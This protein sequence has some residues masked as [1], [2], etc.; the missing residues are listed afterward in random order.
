MYAQNCALSS[1]PHEQ[2]EQ[3]VGILIDDFVTILNSHPYH[4]RGPNAQFTK[5]FIYFYHIKLRLKY[6]RHQFGREYSPIVQSQSVFF[7]LFRIS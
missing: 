5:I 6:F 3:K 1:R 2:N 4:T 7:F